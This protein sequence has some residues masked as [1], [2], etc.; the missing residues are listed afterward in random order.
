MTKRMT[1]PKLTMSDVLRQAIR[2]GGLPLLR[3]AQETGVA[4]AS[5]TRFVRGQR[6]LRLDCADK[7]AAYFDLTLTHK[8]S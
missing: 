6:S 8:D 4:R 7:L 5:L 2:D 1:A 3:L